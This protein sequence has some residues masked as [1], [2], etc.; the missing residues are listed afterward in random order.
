MRIVI[1]DSN[2]V[3]DEPERAVLSAAGLTVERFNCRTEEEMIEAGK[4]A[5]AVLV[6]FAPVTR[7]VIEAW[8]SCRLI[9]RY[10]IGYDNVYIPAADG[11][12]IAVCNVPSY[13][14][15]EVA[16]H[17]CALLLS[18][19]RKVVAFD[20]SVRSGEWNVEKVAKPMPRFA[21]SVVGLIGF[22]RIG[23]RVAERIRP[24]G[25][26]ILIYDPYMSADKAEQLGVHKAATLEEL[27][28]KADAISLHSPLTEDTKHLINATT[29]SQ[30]KSGAL[31]V[32]TSRGG[33]IDTEALATAL[34]EGT[35]GGAA[36]DVFEQE[37]LQNDHPLRSCDNLILTPHA[38]YYSDSALITLQTQAAE[39]V[40]R[41]AQG[42]P[43]ASQVNRPSGGQGGSR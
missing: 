14:L 10:G 23:A 37:P 36:I 22:G 32:N 7:R 20:R 40:V 38:A 25:F 15:D 18:G 3:S 2:F 4:G 26:Q 19:L 41:L 43:L 29:L 21:D 13:C 17:T 5:D 31:L 33:L 1:T 30:M 16:D 24:F 11:A 28:S 42:L 9:V 8:T 39:E 12:G 27:L 6:Q 35:I 34:N